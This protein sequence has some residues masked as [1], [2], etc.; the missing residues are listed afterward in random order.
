VKVGE[1]LVRYQPKVNDILTQT[2]KKPKHPKK[3]TK[4]KQENKKQVWAQGVECLLSKQEALVQP[5]V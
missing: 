4:T 1:L 2:H 3:K 5:P